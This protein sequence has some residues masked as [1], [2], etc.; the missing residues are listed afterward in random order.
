MSQ[1][2]ALGL[3]QTP[4]GANENLWKGNVVC[5]GDGVG[6]LTGLMGS[7]DRLDTMG[8]KVIKVKNIVN[9]D[10]EILSSKNKIPWSGHSANYAIKDIY[11][12]LTKNKFFF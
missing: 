3:I 7:M 10:I 12:I 1:K 6:L 5:W 8:T 9:P 11:K 4:F 2:K